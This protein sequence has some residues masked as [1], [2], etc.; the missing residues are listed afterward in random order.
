MRRIVSFVFLAAWVAGGLAWADD[1]PAEAEGKL[2]VLTVEP[3]A[4][5]AAVLRYR[6]L[7]DT[8]SLQRGNAAL[9]YTKLAILMQG[10]TFEKQQEQLDQWL[11]LPTDKLPLDEMRKALDSL[12]GWIDDLN[13]AAR[14]SDCDWQLPVGDRPLFSILLPEIQSTRSM[15]RLLACK[16]RLD[17]A[18]GRLDDALRTLQSGLTLGQNV[19]RGPTLIHGLV[20]IAISHVMFTAMRDLQQH[21][22]SPNLYWALTALPS[23]L[24]DMRRAADVESSMLYLSYPELRALH[25]GDHTPRDWPAVIDRVLGELSPQGGRGGSLN[26]LAL[27]AVALKAY[28]DAK[29]RLI[30]GGR[31]AREV[32]AMPVFEVIAI[33]ALTTYD[34][35]RDRTMCWLYFPYWQARP[36]F[37]AAEK[38]LQTEGRNR[39]SIPLA[40]LLVPAIRSVSRAKAR[41]DREVALLRVIEAA[42]MY[43]ASHEGQ[44]PHSLADIREVP[45]PDDPLTGRP[46]DYTLRDDAALLGSSPGGEPA[47]QNLY[48]RYELRLAR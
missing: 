38:Y 45:L 8:S 11:E 42:R 25:D 33:D 46:F 13:L 5:A 26:R 12:G 2:I 35:L 7:P 31:P 10:G 9:V 40:T 24:F 27:T 36:H 41:M 4:P 32:D 44:L 1:A 39:E 19:S 22:Q 6:L 30:E 29:R 28:P 20:G 17:V 15:A 47:E 48:L 21:P 23:P 16:A 43:A 14:L 37:E 3:A 34:E 18:E